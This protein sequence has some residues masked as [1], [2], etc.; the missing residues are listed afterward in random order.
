M[1]SRALRSTL[2]VLP[3]PLVVALSGAGCDTVEPTVKS[4]VRVQISGEDAAV[5][6]FPFPLAGEVALA[7]GWEL[8]FTHVLVSVDHVTLSENPDLSPS[9]QSQTGKVVATLDGPWI[10]DLSKPG[11]ETGA[12]GEGKAILLGRIT[13]QNAN[14]GEPFDTTQR[15]AFGFEGTAASAAA[16]RVNLDADADKAADEMIT[17]GWSVLY[18]GTAT[19]RGTACET[20]DPSYDYAPIPTSFAFSLG[21]ASP[22]AY[23]NCQNQDN[24]GTPFDGEEYQRGIPIPSN[25]EGVA[26]ITMH[27]EH[28]FFT[29]VVHDSALRFDHFAARL[30]GAPA[31]TKLTLDDLAGVDIAAIT[32]RAGAPL[33]WRSCDGTALP[34]GAQM[35]LATGAV[36]VDP[37][38]DPGAALRDVRDFV[39][40]VQSTQGHL[41]GGE[42]LCFVH[43]KYPSPP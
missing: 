41:N 39:D 34:A 30:G 19:F 29:D 1:R 31:G 32:D 6:G 14:G 36:P 10:V 20:S 25:A 43:R 24:A 33:P 16:T 9:D 17:K 7:D 22:T 42:G 26:Q 35:R 40:Y 5:E 13:E 18:V 15:Y 8:S 11:T 4:G 12:G 21:F 2:A 23:A 38:A 27:L 3:F 37:T 28:P